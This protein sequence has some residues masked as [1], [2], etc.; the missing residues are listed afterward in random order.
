MLNESPVTLAGPRLSDRVSSPTLDATLGL[1]EMGE[2]RI[3]TLGAEVT[4]NGLLA[5]ENVTVRF[6]FWGNE[7][8]ANHLPLFPM[9]DG[10]ILPGQGRR[11]LL[12]PSSFSELRRIVLVVRQS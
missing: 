5:L 12:P 8:A 3:P 7:S 1:F 2:T 4:N 9:G 6:E 10:P 11:Y